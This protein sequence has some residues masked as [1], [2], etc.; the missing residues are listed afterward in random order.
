MYLK[1]IIIIVIE[2]SGCLVINLPSCLI[3]MRQGIEDIH[4]PETN[5]QDIDEINL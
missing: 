4:C 2:H 5:N 3:T 1:K